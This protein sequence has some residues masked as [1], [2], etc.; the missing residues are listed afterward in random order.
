MFN[1]QIVIA[2]IRIDVANSAEASARPE[3]LAGAIES[4]RN[5]GLVDVVVVL[6]DSESALSA[7]RA[8]N[9]V[10]RFVGASV[11]LDEALDGLLDS[12]DG[13]IDEDENPWVLVFDLS[14]DDNR[15]KAL[16]AAAQNGQ[17]GDLRRLR[18]G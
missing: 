6:T 2:A 12:E 11:S 14:F 10:D 5:T 3:L 9:A 17:P 8:N 1:N 15:A 16:A 18:R 7:A 13:F 4:V